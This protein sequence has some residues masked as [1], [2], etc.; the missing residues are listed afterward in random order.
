MSTFDFTTALPNRTGSANTQ[1]AYY[2]W[3]DRFLV[4]TA[5]LKPTRGDARL[6]R[7]ANLSLSQLLPHLT[8]EVLTRWLNALV[9]AQHGRQSLDQAR[10]AVVTLTE[11][12]GQAG[13]VDEALVNAMHNVSVPPIPR[14]DAPETLLTPAQIQQLM[15]AARDIA[16][17]QN[18]L[19]RNSVVVNM[20]CTMILRREELSAA[21]WG[22]IML[23]DNRVIL[24][25]DDDHLVVPR[26]VLTVIDR[27]RSAIA[28]SSQH[29]D[30]ASPLIRRIWK[31]GRIAKDGL[32]ADGIW[33]IIR[34]AS[35]AAGL[36]HVTPDD[37]RRS[38]VAG[39]RDSGA[40]VEEISRVLRHRHVG[41]TERFLAKLPNPISDD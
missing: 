39:L 36:G 38:A 12:L 13:L 35:R 8:P 6:E 1:R 16:T 7:M 17:T 27:W 30:P 22:D 33:L 34:D 18:Q 9:K 41:I 24:R 28:A 21:R 15:I 2:R 14:A 4:D 11:L 25:I 29:H 10:A 5:G 40:T 23:R 26:N 32:S 37:L 20:L 3:V 19:L 31:G